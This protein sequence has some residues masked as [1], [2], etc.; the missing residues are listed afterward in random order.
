MPPKNMRLLSVHNRLALQDVK[1]LGVGKEHRNLVHQLHGVKEGGVEEER[2][3]S[4]DS[5]PKIHPS[6]PHRHSVAHLQTLK[7]A[8]KPAQNE[9]Q[10]GHG[11]P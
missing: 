2:A 1:H 4:N 9:S 11:I 5:H 3:D 7:T 8:V 10:V 6:V